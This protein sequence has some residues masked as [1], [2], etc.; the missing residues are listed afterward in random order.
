MPP[1]QIHDIVMFLGPFLLEILLKHVQAGGGTGKGIGLAA[2]LAGAAVLETL[3]VNYYFHEL[4]RICL[5]LKTGL[6]DALYRKSLR[7]SAAARA[8]LGAGA[9]VNLQ[10]NDAAKL[11][12][13][14]QYLHM[15]SGVPRVGRAKC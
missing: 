4:F 11:W 9:I 2:A 7:V 13:L 8:E 5:H 10:S 15:V 14:P 6:V 1:L 12:S 3:T